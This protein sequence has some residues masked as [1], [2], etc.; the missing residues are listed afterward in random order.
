MTTINDLVVTNSFAPDDKL[1][2]WSNANGVT[3]ALPISVL[4]AAFL[5]QDDIALIA[6]SSSVETFIAG[7]DFIP[8]TTLSLNLVHNYV[9]GDN[10]EVHFDAAFQGPDQFSLV[11]TTITF[12]SPIPDGV[13]KVYVSGG[14]VRLIGAP[15]DGTVFTS[16]IVDGAITAPKLAPNAVTAPALAAGAVVDAS[17]ASP[18]K[19]FNRINDVPSVTDFGIPVTATVL[20]SAV[21]AL[22]SAGGGLLKM[23]S[24]GA[25][26][27]PTNYA[28]VLLEC[29]GPN[30][31]VTQIGETPG[32]QLIA[33]KAL[34][35]QDAGN[36][37][38]IGHSLLHLENQAVGSG[39]IGITFG[40][41]FGLTVSLLKKDFAT[42]AV[43]GQL[44]GGYFFVRQGGTTGV[45]ACGL[46]TDVRQYGT[47]F[48]AGMESVTAQ[49]NSGV[50]V[51]QVNTQLCVVYGGPGAPVGVGL[52]MNCAT[53]LANTTGLLL[54]TSNSAVGKWATL[55]T[56][57]VDGTTVFNVDGN[58]QMTTVAAVSCQG[59]VSAQSLSILGAASGLAG[60]GLILGPGTAT[61]ASAGS[62]TLPTNPSGFLVA[63]INTTEIKIPYYNL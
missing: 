63:F 36:H 51:M 43:N 52:V 12:I 47:G 20:A 27:L 37:I 34:I 45:D 16:T 53:G 49:E 31:P 28:G 10:I 50:E 9:S 58:G 35:G 60:G 2:M 62:Q 55:I 14:A 61:T 24:H 19:L 32:S 33:Q 46:L 38:G 30:V 8:G 7:V 25:V 56:A 21:A 39:N 42:T 4:S 44:N 54:Q 5:T 13:S 29:D 18:S 59:R 17:V 26:A 3:R 23:G 6:A 40:A 11:N 22:Q 48:T 15:S 1:P 41:D 57:T